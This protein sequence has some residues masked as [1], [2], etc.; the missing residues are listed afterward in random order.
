M[1]DL[2]SLEQSHQRVDSLLHGVHPGDVFWPVQLAAG[3]LAV[4]AFFSL[5]LDHFR[6]AR[7]LVVLQVLMVV[8]LWGWAMDGDLIL[9]PA[10]IHS[11]GARAETMRGVLPTLVIGFSLCLPALA[12][13]FRVFRSASEEYERRVLESVAASAAASAEEGGSPPE[14]VLQ[15]A[16][17]TF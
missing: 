9:N 1:V 6:V 4:V 12:Y 2:A 16:K 7:I 17:R 5:A 13:L 8:S 10:N 14:P 15:Q 11:S 3:A